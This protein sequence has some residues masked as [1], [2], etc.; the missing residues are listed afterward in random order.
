MLHMS[1]TWYLTDTLVSIQDA[2]MLVL[3]HV[4][5]TLMATDHVGLKILQDASCFECHATWREA[6][7]KGEVAASAAILQAGHNLDCLMLRYQGV[8]WQDK[9]KWRCGS[10]VAPHQEGTYDGT[11]LNPL[12]V[13]LQ[14]PLS[15]RHLCATS[16]A[17][18]FCHTVHKC[19]VAASS[20]SLP[21]FLPVCYCRLNPS[22]GSDSIIYLLYMAYDQHLKAQ[23]MRQQQCAYEHLISHCISTV[24]NNSE[25]CCPPR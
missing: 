18:L 11:S 13:G 15:D 23:S 3:P 19:C 25:L 16:Q 10:M 14:L 17:E 5:S 8:D 20:S 12:E 24:C 7:V 4:E 9:S 1:Y 6:K 21:S 2:S 22:S